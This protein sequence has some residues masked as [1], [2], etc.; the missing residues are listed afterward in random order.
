[1]NT[2]VR[3]LQF[4]YCVY[5]FILFVIIMLGVFPFVMLSL[6]FGKLTGGNLIYKLCMIWAKVW[7]FLIGIA[8][9]EIYEYPH[10]STKQYIFVANH[11]SYMDIPPLVLIAHQPVRILGKYEMVKIPVFGWIYRAAVVLVDRKNA[12]TRSKSVRAL[13]SALRQGISIF[14]FPEG[15]FNMGTTPLKDFFD[16]AFRIAIE[17]ETPI[18]PV[19]LVDTLERLHYNSIFSLT[20]GKSRVIFLDEIPVQGL[21]LKDIPFLKEKVYDIMDEGLRRYRQYPTP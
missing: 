7:Y 14:I 16:G 17:T 11:I 13:K 5:A 20:P 8:H 21:T 19:L 6:L 10:D 12:E 3:L 2:L 9:K 4:L 18:K 15:T 1:M